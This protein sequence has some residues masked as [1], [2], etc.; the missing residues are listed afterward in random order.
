MRGQGRDRRGRV[1]RHRPR[2]HLVGRLHG[3][4][5]AQ[6]IQLGIEYDPQPPYDSGA[7]SKAPAEIKALVEAVMADAEERAMA[8]G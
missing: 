1:G 4:E 6:A 5:V 8:A 7:P 2:A 3:D